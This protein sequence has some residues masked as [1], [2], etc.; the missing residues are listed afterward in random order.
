MKKPK[1][2]IL[3]TTASNTSVSKVNNSIAT[4]DSLLI[5]VKKNWLYFAILTAMIVVV[6]VNAIANGFVSDDRGLIS[7]GEKI[8]SFDFI[9]NRA[10]GPLG[11]LRALVWAIAY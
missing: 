4:L 5:F 2:P 11:F 8:L 1:A 3:Q 10:A 7:E 9:F 6:Y